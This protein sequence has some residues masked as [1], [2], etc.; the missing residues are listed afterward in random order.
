MSFA[1][2]RGN[3]SGFSGL[4]RSFVAGLFAVVFSMAYGA[5][6]SG[7]TLLVGKDQDLKVPSD[8]MKLATAGDRIVIEPGEY[9]DCAVWRQDRLTIEGR[10]PG[11]VLTDK[12]CNGKALF[13]TA[14]SDITIRNITFTRARVAD[15]NGAGIRAEGKNLTVENC[16]FINNQEGIL[17]GEMPESTIIIRNSEFT[18]N[19]SC[20]NSCAH[21]VYIGHISLLHVENTKFLETKHAHHI[22]SRADRTEV[23]GSNI[24]DGPEGTGSYLVELPVGG[25]L[26]L[27]GNVLEKGPKNEN[28][29]AAVMIGAEGVSNRTK[30]LI[31]EKNRFTNDGPPTAFVKNLT[32]T[33]AQL[34]GNSISGN[35]VKALV[36]DGEVQ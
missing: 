10:G 21:G 32:A 16:R 12:T 31:I 26:L 34:V 9:F 11:V 35:A 36:G 20:E 14:G 18:R 19:G 24:Q 28:H 25:S 30:E 13:I 5:Q 17:A 7:K 22:K 4:Y 27:T 3:F 6:V 15:G 2:I 8:A 33:E 29:T 1:V 23:I